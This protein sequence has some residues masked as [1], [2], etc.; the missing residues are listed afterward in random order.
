MLVNAPLSTV[1]SNP[2]TAPSPTNAH[3][4]FATPTPAMWN[5]NSFFYIFLTDVAQLS[6]GFLQ[7]I[8]SALV[9]ADATSFLEFFRPLPQVF[10]PKSPPGLL[11]DHRD[12]LYTASMVGTFVG[13]YVYHNA[14]ISSYA[15]ALDQPYYPSDHDQQQVLDGHFACYFSQNSMERIPPF[16]VAH[17][18]AV[19]R[20][21]N[22]APSLFCFQFTLGRRRR[23]S[24]R[25]PNGGTG[26]PLPLGPYQTRIHLF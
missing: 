12:E 14:A 8:R 22:T 7:A 23:K 3:G 24:K 20:T 21:H 15:P 4:I 17:D 25:S 10:L 5:E 16:T 26:K 1:H 6:V 11:H 19:A 13:V 9:I 18:E 2:S